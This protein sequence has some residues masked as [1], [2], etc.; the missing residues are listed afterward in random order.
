MSSGRIGKYGRGSIGS[1]RPLHGQASR[2][3]F[4]VLYSGAVTRI[5]GN[6]EPYPWIRAS[7]APAVLRSSYLVL[8]GPADGPSL[9]TDFVFINRAGHALLYFVY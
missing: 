5:A 2:A 6:P 8:S 4:P 1:Q 3:D 7:C 9:Q